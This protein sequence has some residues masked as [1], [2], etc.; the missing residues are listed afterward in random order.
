VFSAISITPNPTIILMRIKSRRGCAN[1]RRAAIEVVERPR[2][3][4][5]KASFSF[6]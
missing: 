6:D 3:F 5:I 1:T 2:E 4:Q